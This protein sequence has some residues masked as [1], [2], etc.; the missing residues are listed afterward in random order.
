MTSMLYKKKKLKMDALS[1]LEQVLREL[2]S[3]AFDKKHKEFCRCCGR[4]IS[5]SS[6]VRQK[7]WGSTNCNHRQRTKI[8]NYGPAIVKRPTLQEPLLLW[9][10]AQ[11]CQRH[12][13]QHCKKRSSG[14][15]TEGE[16]RFTLSRDQD[17]NWLRSAQ[18]GSEQNE[19]S[20]YG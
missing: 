10:S 12:T 9:L 11:I 18:S 7:W 3:Q 5:L 20:G 2:V 17:P 8:R 15:R 1:A 13:G 19:A 6:V 4:M 14:H 16:F